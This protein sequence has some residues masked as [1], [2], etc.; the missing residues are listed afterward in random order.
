MNVLNWYRRSL[1]NK[2]IV[3]FL[4]ISIFPIGLASYIF[5][6]YAT[7]LM[8]EKDAQHS[9]D[10]NLNK[11]NNLDRLFASMENAISNI[12]TSFNTTYLLKNITGTNY[13]TDRSFSVLSEVG[14][15]LDSYKQ[16]NDN[17]IDSFYVLPGRGG[18]PIFKGAYRTEFNGDYTQLPLYRD[19][20]NNPTKMNWK[21]EIDRSRGAYTL[22]LSKTV[23]DVFEDKPLGIAVIYLNV[24]NL[25][26]DIQ[27]SVL[28]PGEQLFIVDEQGQFIF[29]TDK[30]RIG[31]R[32]DPSEG[33][34][35][36][37]GSENGSFEATLFGGKAIVTYAQSKVNQW[38]IVN[39]MP[40]QNAVKGIDAI[41]RIAIIIT[42]LAG[43]IAMSVA[44][45]VYIGLYRPI[46]GIIRAMKTM[47]RGNFG[48][49][50]KLN[51]EDELGALS[52]SFN[53]LTARVGE[54]IDDVTL[55][56]RKKKEF[57]IRAL[58]AQ[59]TPHFLYN[60]LNSI[61]SLS[62]LGRNEDIVEM[63][64]AL[65]D[66]LRISASH[67]HDT[68]TIREEMAYVQSYMKIMAYRYDTAFDFIHEWDEHDLD[69]GILKF[70][71]QPVVENCI[72]HAFD[73]EQEYRMIKIGIYREEN[74]ITLVVSDN[75]N[76]V[77]KQKKPG[78]A[79][80]SG[81]GISNINER[82]KL[83]Y[84]E[85]YGLRI[86]AE[87]GVGTKVYITIPALKGDDTQEV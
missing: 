39:S 16:A 46:S 56:Q 10:M 75:G 37:L 13:E 82:L 87:P 52:R 11:I 68:I 36:V 28:Q 71:V 55:E 74:T 78:V 70:T 64:G 76:G 67:K 9:Y 65:I 22:T 66:L 62:R 69:Y 85:P 47:E 1:K 21:F 14:A 45:L 25:M 63:S 23:F 31:E 19:T 33:L 24:D 7:G 77:H 49:R 73:P 18:I 50:V 29:H 38:T 81:M 41:S 57:E 34:A 79:K 8:V 44:I 32:L 51:R 42:C 4:A 27:S 54:L 59:I 72:I 61:Q 40:Y 58:Q 6:Q 3:Y 80:F 12:A 5:Y 26:E 15:Q 17:L 35:R 53:F 83:N 20:E 84:G 2:L 30:R 43:L 60:T 86:E 48:V